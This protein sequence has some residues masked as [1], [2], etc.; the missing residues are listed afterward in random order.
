M[1]ELNLSTK[2]GQNIYERACHYDGTY[3]YQVYKNLVKQK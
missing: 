1:K 2:T 3:L